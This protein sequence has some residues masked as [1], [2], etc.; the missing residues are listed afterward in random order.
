ML[1]GYQILTNFMGGD[2]C[3]AVLLRKH[4]NKD[5]KWEVQVMYLIFM[6]FLTLCID[7]ID[8]LKLGSTSRIMLGT[9]TNKI[10]LCKQ[11]YKPGEREEKLTFPHI[12]NFNT[13]RR[14]NA[15]LDDVESFRIS[16]E[17][18]RRSLDTEGDYCFIMYTIKKYCCAGSLKVRRAF[19]LMT[20]E[21]EACVTNMRL[22]REDL[23][24]TDMND[25]YAGRHTVLFKNLPKPFYRYVRFPQDTIN[26][27]AHACS[28]SGRTMEPSCST[29]RR[30][31]RVY[32]SE[33]KNRIRMYL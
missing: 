8:R 9:R 31:V 20:M 11:E 6:Y 30:F 29:K 32:S 2:A 26:A 4:S 28:K 33:H 10:Y 17:L 12:D 22:Q 19:L 23:S 14:R 5:D 21:G 16:H 25:D 3:E 24:P 13:E 1:E 7:Q 18:E 15:I 27:T